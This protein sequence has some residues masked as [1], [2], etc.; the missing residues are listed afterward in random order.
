MNSGQ[1]SKTS[2]LESLTDLSYESNTNS[3]DKNSE[4]SNNTETLIN[5]HSKNTVD[6]IMNK[7]INNYR[8]L[9]RFKSY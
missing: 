5:N 1:E 6:Y 4:P 3:K 2:I 9:F 8:R 7:K